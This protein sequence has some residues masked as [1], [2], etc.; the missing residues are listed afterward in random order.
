[1]PLTVQKKDSAPE[2]T[3]F[4]VFLMQD[5]DLTRAEDHYIRQ[6][7]TIS[8]VKGLKSAGMRGLFVA[9]I[10]HSAPCS[11]TQ[12]ARRTPSG[13][14]ALS[15]S[16]RKYEDGVS[17]LRFVKNALQRVAT[18]LNSTEE[19][20]DP[21]LLSAL[22]S[23]DL[24]DEQQTAA[25]GGARD[26]RGDIPFSRT[27]VNVDGSGENF[28]L[29]KTTNGLRISSDPNAGAA[30]DRL[31]IEAAYE[32]RRGDPF[33]HYSPF[34]FDFATSMFDVLAK[35]ADIVKAERNQI[36]V[37]IVAPEFTIRVEGFDPTRDV[38]VRVVEP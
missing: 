1:M 38:R 12:K 10:D 16:S 3:H 26:R 27:E 18:F 37:K 31:L 36:E 9:E 13:M 14:S 5:A 21:D 17:V 32:V 8:G 33:R 29:S 20:I 24:P 30:P 6:G 28:L 7:I 34:D 22:F 25:A 2:P 19:G 15:T 35:G 4:D 11:A 23:I